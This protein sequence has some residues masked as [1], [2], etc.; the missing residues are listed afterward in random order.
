MSELLEGLFVLSSDGVSSSSLSLSTIHEHLDVPQIATEEEDDD[1]D[2]ASRGS[3]SFETSGVDL[4]LPDTSQIS[5]HRLSSSA[6]SAFSKSFPWTPEEV[7]VDRTLHT[8]RSPCAFSQSNPEANG[9]TAT[10]HMTQMPSPPATPIPESISPIEEELDEDIFDIRDIR[11]AEDGK[12]DIST[13]SDDQWTL[14]AESVNDGSLDQKSDGNLPRYSALV[15][16]PT[17][18]KFHNE[19]ALVYQFTVEEKSKPE[20]SLI[21]KNF[22]LNPAP[23]ESSPTVCNPPVRYTSL[24]LPAARRQR[25]VLRTDLLV[26][27]ASQQW[28]REKV[29]GDVRKVAQRLPWDKAQKAWHLV[30][31]AEAAPI[32]REQIATASQDSIIPRNPLSPLQPTMAARSSMLPPG[33]M[34]WATV[35]S[36][37]PNT[38]G[39]PGLIFRLCIAWRLATQYNAINHPFGAQEEVKVFVLGR[40]HEEFYQFYEGLLGKFMLEPRRHPWTQS[41]EIGPRAN[42]SLFPM[43][44][45]LDD[46]EF[47]SA[48]HGDELT[49]VRK[50]D[51][52]ETWTQGLM[53]LKGTK[54]D[55][56]L[57]SDYVRSWMAPRR[58]GD[59]ERSADNWRK[60]GH[61]E[62]GRDSEGIARVL[63]RLW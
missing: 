12:L 60:D 44:P 61:E 57:A 38:A 46:E 35:D 39:Q 59:C 7:Q 45:P 54:M 52:L 62:I 14:R 10:L 17:K 11:A 18:V 25:P 31:E 63:E 5:T 34:E 24:A 22:T 2:A 6:P 53:R 51:M 19:E 32:D 33:R 42:A 20:T 41:E 1:F 15:Y 3:S 23:S 56:V 55:F 40:T 47:D 37:A 27:R 4:D 48:I 49:R 16:T 28:D 13:L 58:E 9:A 8:K 43:E 30:R 50:V 36:A 26:D 29:N 21:D